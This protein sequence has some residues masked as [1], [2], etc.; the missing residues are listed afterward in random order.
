M[1]KWPSHMYQVQFTKNFQVKFVE[2]KARQI[3]KDKKDQER[4]VKLIH[5]MWL[6]S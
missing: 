1:S 4:V 2:E 5:H 3:Q 6:F